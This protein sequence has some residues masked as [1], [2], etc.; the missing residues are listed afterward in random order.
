MERLHYWAVWSVNL[1]QLQ[2]PSLRAHLCLPR[3]CSG[4]KQLPT[5]CWHCHLSVVWLTDALNPPPWQQHRITLQQISL[6]WTLIVIGINTS[7]AR[8]RN[9]V[10]NKRRC[11][12]KM[13]GK[14]M[15][16]AGTAEKVGLQQLLEWWQRQRR[17]NLVL[18]HIPGLHS[19]DRESGV[20]ERRLACSRNHQSHLSW[21]DVGH[22]LQITGLVDRAES[23]KATVCKETHY[24][25]RIYNIFSVRHKMHG[26]HWALRILENRQNIKFQTSI[27]RALRLT[28][29]WYSLR[30]LTEG[31]P[32]WVDPGGWVD[33]E[34]VCAHCCTNWAN[35]EQLC[36]LRQSVTSSNATSQ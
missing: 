2:V 20:A 22:G 30:L 11:R 35:V 23:V 17:R 27:P 8:P 3:C 24:I 26:N 1:R 12:L 36:W 32:G 29:Y 25:T 34:M 33:T 6:Y 15:R 21:T 14:L 10:K 28:R 16:T 4:T 9:I 7:T 5:V 19:G 31:W 18:Q 13:S